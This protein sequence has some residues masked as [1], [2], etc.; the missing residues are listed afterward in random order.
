M[1]L[2][3]IVRW[4]RKEYLL[5]ILITCIVYKVSISKSSVLLIKSLHL[6]VLQSTFNCEIIPGFL[7]LLNH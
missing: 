6:T 2:I 1:F 5:T 4:E 7:K 3:V